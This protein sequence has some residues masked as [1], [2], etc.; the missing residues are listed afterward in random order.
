M[1][2]TSVLVFNGKHILSLSFIILKLNTHSR[3]AHVY[4]QPH[5]TGFLTGCYGETGDSP[6]SRGSS[7]KNLLIVAMV[8]KFQTIV[9]LTL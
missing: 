4:I 1:L 9:L 6:N 5:L 3:Q 8:R 2:T 7:G